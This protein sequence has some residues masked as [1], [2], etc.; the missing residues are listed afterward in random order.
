M[1]EGYSR[2][3]LPQKLGVRAGS[4]VLL[5]GTP[6]GFDLGPLPER[7]A[8]HARPGSSPYDVAVLFCHDRARLELR[9]PRLHTAVTPGGRL[10][11]AWPKRA[12]GLPTDLDEGVVREFGLAHGRVDVLVCAIDVTWSGLAFVVRLRDR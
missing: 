5:D 12:S 7:V 6:L 9:W 4:R 2:T 10:W 3:P 11:V 8:V 1:S